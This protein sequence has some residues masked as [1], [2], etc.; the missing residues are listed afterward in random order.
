M[1]V[2]RVSD[3]RWLVDGRCVMP[4]LDADPILT[5]L[6]HAVG[7]GGGVT[8][9][10]VEVRELDSTLQLVVRPDGAVTAP[11]DATVTR[12]L[13]RWLRP[14]GALT[15]VTSSPDLT[16]SQMP[17]IAPGIASQEATTGLRDLPRL[18]RGAVT[19]QDWEAVTTHAFERSSIAAEARTM[20][21]NAK[22]YTDAL[23]RVRDAAVTLTDRTMR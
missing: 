9:L 13:M 8:P 3:R 6:E 22:V 19:A 5:V 15:L 4:P 18:V 12:A 16:P 7:A 21:V 2:T 23:G 14:A 10:A 20:G 1:I 17:A 11:A